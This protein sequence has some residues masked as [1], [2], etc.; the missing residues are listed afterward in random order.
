MAQRTAFANSPEPPA[1]FEAS[2]NSSGTGLREKVSGPGVIL[3]PFGTPVGGSGSGRES[4][5]VGRPSDAGS[6]SVSGHSRD[7][8]QSISTVPPGYGNAVLQGPGVGNRYSRVSEGDEG[9]EY[10]GAGM[11]TNMG[12]ARSTAGSSVEDLLGGQEPSFFSVVLNPRRTLRVV[13]LD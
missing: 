2:G 13:N 5:S 9:L 11:N 3:G 1:S 12:G 10:M 7:N 6:G 8:S 4:G